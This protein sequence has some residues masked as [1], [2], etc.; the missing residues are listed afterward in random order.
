MR[1][2]KRLDD[3]YDKL[4]ELHKKNCPD[5]RIAQLFCNLQCFCRQDLFYMED[6]RLLKKFEEYFESMV[7]E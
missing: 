7:A 6:D 4:K 2:P 5:W 3:F 1:D